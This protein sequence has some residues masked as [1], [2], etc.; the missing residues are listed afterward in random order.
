VLASAEADW[1]T[2]DVHAPQSCEFADAPPHSPV[3][4]RCPGKPKAGQ[5]V[6]VDCLDRL[7]SSI[8]AANQMDPGVLV[9]GLM[10]VGS[11]LPALLFC[12]LNPPWISHRR[13][14]FTVR[15]GRSLISS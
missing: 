12:S 1:G 10:S 15:L 2:V 4:P 5:N 7:G 3:G 13:P 14:R 11:K 8:V 6:V 9:M